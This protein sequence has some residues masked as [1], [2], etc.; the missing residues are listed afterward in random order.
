MTKRRKL[1]PGVSQGSVLS[2]LLFIIYTMG[3][4]NNWRN[5]T[6][7]SMYAADIALRCTERNTRNMVKSLYQELKDL[8]NWADELKLEL[9]PNKTKTAFYTTNRKNFIY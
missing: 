3:L 4:K 1:L 6:P 8:K 5:E 9:N 7:V 2:P